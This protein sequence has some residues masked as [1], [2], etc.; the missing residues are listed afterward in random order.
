[1]SQ[2]NVEIVRRVWDAAERRDTEAVFA[3]YDPAVVWDASRIP[4]TLAGVYHGHEGVRR[5]FRDW[6][7]SFEAH[8]T[9]PEAFI[10]AGDNVSWAFG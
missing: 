2:E 3:L 5:F 7:E 4:E 9:R 6:L 10:D 8:D 1:M